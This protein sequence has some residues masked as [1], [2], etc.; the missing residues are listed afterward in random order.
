MQF[1]NFSPTFFLVLIFIK[2]GPFI[3]LSPLIILHFYSVPFLYC[4]FPLTSAEV[5]ERRHGTFPG[6]APP[7]A[8]C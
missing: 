8:L 5:R 2:V 6:H 3:I 1:L 7:A 4:P